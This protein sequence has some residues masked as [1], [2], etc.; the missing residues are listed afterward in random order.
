MEGKM[1]SSAEARAEALRVAD[2]I[3]AVTDQGL[4]ERAIR[5]GLTPREL[6]VLQLV[7]HGR[8]NQEIA[9]TLFI[10]IPTV[11]RHLTTIFGKLG[12]STRGDAA[13]FAHTH[14]FA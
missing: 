6:E 7:A 8:T 9:D 4:N 14:R 1:L 13:A 3:S 12:V 11:K 5:H 2:A 10:S